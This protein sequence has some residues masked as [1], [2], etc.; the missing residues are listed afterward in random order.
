VDA[1]SPA[2]PSHWPLPLD[3]PAAVCRRAMRAADVPS[4]LRGAGQQPLGP[5]PDRQ[6]GAV[7][8]GRAARPGDPPAVL[9]AARASPL[10]TAARASRPNPRT[11]DADA[12]HPG[13]AAQG[14]QGLRPAR[15]DGPRPVGPAAKGGRAIGDAAD[16]DVSVLAGRV[17]VPKLYPVKAERLAVARGELHQHRSAPLPHR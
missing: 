6:R 10:S 14:D 8:S 12:G 11:R 5:S 3:E 17:Y 7:G 13:R 16:D 4:W 2:R 9:W 15:R 1:D